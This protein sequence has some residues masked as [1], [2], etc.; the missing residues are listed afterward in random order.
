MR[1]S[2]FIFNCVHSLYQKC[3]KINSNRG[4]SYID[5]PDW[6]KI[7]KATINPINK[8]DNK[9]FQYTVTIALNHEEIGKKSQRIS[10]IK[11]FIDKYNWEGVN[12]QS[13]KDYWKTFEKNNLT[14]ALNVF[15]LKKNKNISCLKKSFK[16]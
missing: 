1:G 12:Y 14:I 7:K 4:G 16:A 9:C 2:Y 8:N 15:M 11:L 13:R 10:K 3:H 6:I 5:S